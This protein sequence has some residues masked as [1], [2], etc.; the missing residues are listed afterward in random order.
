GADARDETAW[1]LVGAVVDGQG[2]H[3]GD[4]GKGERGRPNPDAAHRASL[5]SSLGNASSSAA[6]AS[7]KRQ[8]AR[9]GSSISLDTART[10]TAG[11]P[12]RCAALRTAKPSMASTWQTLVP[13]TRALVPIG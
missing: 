1:N 8:R 5:A 9:S 13:P 3:R 12:A 4:R 10:S 2:G 7:S 11:T 6:S